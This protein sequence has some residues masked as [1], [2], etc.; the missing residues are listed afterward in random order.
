V[1]SLQFRDILRHYSNKGLQGQR[2][3][4]NRVGKEKVNAND[5]KQL[6]T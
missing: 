2:A 5:R 6:T 1:I 4:S 3:V